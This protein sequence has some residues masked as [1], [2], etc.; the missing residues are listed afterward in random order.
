MD[1]HLFTE[2]SPVEVPIEQEQGIYIS[3]WYSRERKEM[4][5][6]FRLFI[7]GID[8]DGRVANFV[9]TEQILQLDG[10][11]CSYVQVEI[12]PICSIFSLSILDTWFRTLFLDAITR[13]S[14]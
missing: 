10:V 14:L 6:E 2:L 13:S 8:D 1:I 7:R 11:A 12:L 9:E 4:C 3:M 5:S